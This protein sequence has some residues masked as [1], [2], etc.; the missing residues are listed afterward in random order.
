MSVSRFEVL[1]KSFQWFLC[2]T[3]FHLTRRVG[4][5]VTLVHDHLIHV[6]EDH[7]IVPGNPVT[8]ASR[9]FKI[10][11]LCHDLGR[12]AVSSHVPRRLHHGITHHYLNFK[13]RMTSTAGGHPAGPTNVTV[14]SYDSESRLPGCFFEWPKCPVSNNYLH[15]LRNGVHFSGLFFI[16]VSIYSIRNSNFK[17]FRIIS[18]C[19]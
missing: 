11:R 6:T 8:T 4:R 19:P 10:K 16:Y 5:N 15:P 3:E 14:L 2:F 7:R 17:K 9:P 1:F 13:F 12:R 18:F